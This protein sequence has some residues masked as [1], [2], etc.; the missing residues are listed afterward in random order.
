MAFGGKVNYIC[1]VGPLMRGD[2]VV[3]RGRK[4]FRVA[5]LKVSV[6]HVVLKVITLSSFRVVMNVAQWRVGKVGSCGFDV[7][8]LRVQVCRVSK[9]V[10]LG[11]T[12]Y[13]H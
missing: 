5:K 8:V 9:R 1:G 2:L 4:G 7:V 6:S 11:F 13:R 3:K 10:R 12:R